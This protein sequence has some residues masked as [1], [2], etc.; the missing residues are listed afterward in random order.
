VPKPGVQPHFEVTV[1]EPQKIGVD[2][3]NARIV[4][5]V[6]TKV[7]IFIWINGNVN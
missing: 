2:A 7:S 4:Y 6:R 1:S 5:K 3:I